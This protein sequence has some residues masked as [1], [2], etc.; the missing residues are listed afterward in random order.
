MTIIKAYEGNKN[1]A[2]NENNLIE[3]KRHIEVVMLILSTMKTLNIQ[4]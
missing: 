3:H 1:K 2:G 4:E